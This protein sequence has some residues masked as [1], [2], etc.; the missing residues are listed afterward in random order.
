[1]ETAIIFILILGLLVLVH[2]LGHFVSAVKLGV[3]VEEFAIGFPPKIFAWKR[4]GIK[5]S[6]NW[7]PMGGF[8]KIKGE[9]GEGLDDPRSFINQPAW[10][11]LIIV[12]A[13]VLMNFVLA[14]VLLSVVFMLGFPQELSKDM[15]DK[16][17]RDKNV[18]ILQVAKG[19]PANKVGLEIGDK[20]LE[21]NGQSFDNYEEVYAQLEFLRGENIELSVLKTDNQKMTY[22][23]KHEKL[24][25]YDESM[26]GVGISETGIV[27]YGF[28][29]SISQGFKVTISMITGI[30]KALY[31]LIADL[32]TRGKL[33]EGFGGPLA[34]AAVTGDVVKLGFINI[35]YFAA[36]LSINLGVINF[37]PFPAL[38]GGRAMFILAQAATRKK[39]N[40]KVEAWIHNSG[41]I[42]LVTILIAVTLREF[43]I[44]GPS[45]WTAIK[46]WFI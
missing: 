6:I 29:G 46:S 36:I 44:Y 13:G 38:D 18:V 10:K 5:Y 25:G 15:G 7:I 33:A 17:I 37:F 23:L 22:N 4:K 39:L 26:L 28:F 41:F 11:K 43:K 9:Q 8:V 20:I 31:H 45:I 12:S 3:D 35:V 21:V 30:I 2:E 16:N 19:S 34:V 32:I 42:I 1:M 14:F 40:E 27:D 24:E